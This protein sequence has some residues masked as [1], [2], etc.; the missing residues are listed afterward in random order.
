M[1]ALKRILRRFKQKIMSSVGIESPSLKQRKLAKRMVEEM[2]EV[3]Y[4]GKE[5]T[6]Q[7]K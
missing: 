5:K 7:V 6:N 4:G 3:F 1:K 2:G